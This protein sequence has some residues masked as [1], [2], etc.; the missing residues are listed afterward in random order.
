VKK[1]RV[2]LAGAALAGAAVFVIFAAGIFKYEAEGISIDEVASF[3][4]PFKKVEQTNY[5]RICQDLAWDGTY[6]WVINSDDLRWSAG[7]DAPEVLKIH[8]N[9]GTGEGSIVGSF[10]IPSDVQGDNIILQKGLTWDGA[11]LLLASGQYPTGYIHEID[12]GRAVA[13]S[14]TDFIKASGDYYHGY[15]LNLGGD[16]TM[17]LWTA[18][19]GSL[20]MTYSWSEHG[21]LKDVEVHVKDSANNDVEGATVC[22]WQQMYYLTT[23][24]GKD[25][26]CRFK[27]LLFGFDDGKLTATKH[28]YK[29]ALLNDVT[30][31]GD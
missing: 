27:D 1:I 28:N 30:I 22:L 31:G 2:Y 6:L 16:P 13:K 14:R 4:L 23:P 24:T 8:F 11:Y 25:G 26:R 29:P 9:E 17:E 3:Q 12:V 18:E 5:G 7:S 19:P 15:I 10:N 20:S 21:V